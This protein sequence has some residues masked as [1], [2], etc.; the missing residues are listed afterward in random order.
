[1]TRITRIVTR[2]PVPIPDQEAG[3]F[4]DGFLGGGQADALHGLRCVGA[5][6]LQGQRQVRAA[7]GLGD[8]VDFVDDHGAYG[9]QHLAP[10][11]AGQK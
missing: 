10:G 5:Q 1:M 9:A 11:A 7:L 4:L 2:H 6:P 8:G 3:D